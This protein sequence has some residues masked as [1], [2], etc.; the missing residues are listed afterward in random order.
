MKNNVFEHKSLHYLIL[1]FGIPSILSLLIEMLTSITDTAF[2]GNLPVIGANA[3]SS[4]ALLAPLLSIFTALQTLFAMSCGILVAKYFADEHTRQ[5]T[6][7]LGIAMSFLVSSLVSIICAALLVPLLQFIGAEGEVFILAMAYLKIQLSSNVISSVGYTLTCVIRSLGFPKIEMGI[8][9]LSVLT[10]LFCNFLFSFHLDMGIEGLAY[11]SLL[12]ELLC[13]TLSLRFFIKHG[14]LQKRTG[15][16]VSQSFSLVKEMFKI[17]FAQTVIQMLSGCTGFFVNA[18]LLAIGNGLSVAAWSIAQQVYLLLL[19]PIVGLSQGV[20]TII[21]YF[22]GQKAHAQVHRVSSLTKKYCLIYGLSAFLFVLLSGN[23]L[24]L[25]FG[26]NPEIVAFSHQILLIIFS[27][28][29]LVGI[30]Y[31]NLTVLQVTG[32][33]LSAILLVLIRQVIV[34]LPLLFILPL[35]FAWLGE[36]PLTGIFL[37]TPL[38][39]CSVVLISILLKKQNQSA[40]PRLTRCLS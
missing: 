29:P 8:I 20:Q 6:I 16:T 26:R 11:G 10:N 37:A 2:A 14:L 5:M 32:N 22:D 33:E 25:I 19:M 7:L 24:L 27:C 34:L 15:I 4:M 21:A 31:I 12:S 13:L 17:G 30:F 36:S 23:N 3:L 18:Q 40:L 35:I 38:A 1:L 39:D 9:A 28:F